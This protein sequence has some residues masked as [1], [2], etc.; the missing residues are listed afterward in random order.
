MRKALWL[1]VLPPLSLALCSC[2]ASSATPQSGGELSAPAPAGASLAEAGESE[3]NV[4]LDSVPSAVRTAA[5]GAVSGISFSGAERE[6]ENGA[7][8]YTLRGTANGKTYEVEVSAAGKVL[9]VEDGDDCNECDKDDKNE[10]DD[11]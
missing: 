10:K 9:E 3:E 4:A 11:K 1:L 5:Q 2:A 6:T 8:V 7:T